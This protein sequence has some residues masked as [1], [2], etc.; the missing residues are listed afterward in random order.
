MEE[1]HIKSSSHDYIVTMGEGIRSTLKAFL[2][3]EYSSIFIVT[4]DTVGKLYLKDVLGGLEEEKNVFYT[5]V[6]AGEQSKDFETFH[7]LHTTA[8][9]NG[10]DRNSLVVALGGG[11]VG[12]LAGFV[13]ATFMRGID[14]VQVPTTILA[15]DSSVGGKVAINHAFGK[16]LIGSFYPPVAVIY[17]TET[18][19]TLP[20][21]EI[22]SGYAEL[23]KEALI[24]DE[25]S[26]TSVLD[27]DLNKLSS[28]QLRMHIK[29]GI[30][31][32]ASIVQQDER[33]SGVR[34]FLNLG[35]TLGHA[36]E[37]NYGYGK[38]THGEA[39]AIGTLFAL[40]VSEDIFNN[41]L[42]FNDVY[43]WLQANRYPLDSSILVETDA[44]I[45]KMKADKKTVDTN[46]QMVL[47]QNIG[48]PINRTI[49]D[50]E[51]KNY[52][53]SFSKRLVNS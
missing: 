27:A 17:D 35:H 32:K 16:N 13:A 46:I 49:S 42:P 9:E 3:K 33:E 1:I 37:S 12:D 45:N 5:E 24:T 39:V 48:K 14:Y 34:K 31:T 4:D 43:N 36:I 11:V 28:N 21:K 8:L 47:L 50:E 38:L 10:L 29:A 52:L 44:L 18:L 7:R 23:I 19:A 22:R 2:K 6:H 40:H 20:G 53:L 30:A 26:V 15:H 51:L 25:A 41:E